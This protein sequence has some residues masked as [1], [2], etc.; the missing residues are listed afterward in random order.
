[1][2]FKIHNILRISQQTSSIKCFSNWSAC[3][4]KQLHPRSTF[5]CK[6]TTLLADSRIDHHCRNSSLFASGDTSA[7]NKAVSEGERLVGYPTSFMSLRTLLSDELA[8]VALHVRKLVGTNHPILKTAKSFVY[9]GSNLQTRGLVILLLSR[10]AG[11]PPDAQDN[12]HNVYQSQRTLAE[13]SEMIHTA[14]LVHRGIIDL[15]E[16]RPGDGSPDDLEFGNKMSVLSGDFLL[17]NASQGLAKLHNTQVVELVSSAI[18]DY[19]E[20]EFMGFSVDTVNL[21]LTFADWL[22]HVY[23]SNGSLLAKCCQA[24]LILANQ[25]EDMQNRAFQFGK[26]LT[27]AQ[28]LNLD[29]QPF[30]NESYELGDAFNLCSSAMMFHIQ[31]IITTGEALPMSTASNA[32]DFQQLYQ[33][34]AAGPATDTIKSELK[35]YVQAALDSIED[36]EDSESK[37]ALVNIVNSLLEY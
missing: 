36:L 6:Q 14:Y 15:K 26:Y 23:L 7:W 17:A 2:K 3:F 24:A 19:T 35:N 32:A 5:H 4:Q 1:M 10:A 21:Q 34:I 25:D 9:E 29:L 16:I 33:I 13:I 31:H 28:Q 30:V 27:V 12:S 11:L 37:H 18:T 20:S 22:N 8:N